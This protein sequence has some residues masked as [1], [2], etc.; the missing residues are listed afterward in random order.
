MGSLATY[1]AEE[2]K[3][4][5]ILP[6]LMS[7]GGW[8][9]SPQT[10]EAGGMLPSPCRVAKQAL[11][12]AVAGTLL[13]LTVTGTYLQVLLTNASLSGIGVFLTLP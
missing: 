12:A 13:D 10:E 9:S 8:R 7:P 11:E 3:S 6:V 1:K 4:L 2:K 5:V